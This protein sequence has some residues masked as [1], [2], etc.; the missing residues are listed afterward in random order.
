M[1]WFRLRPLAKGEH[2]EQRLSKFFLCP[3]NLFVVP[4]KIRFKHK[5]KT[6]VLPPMTVLALRSLKPRYGL[7][8]ACFV[9]W[10]K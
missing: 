9:L 5:I 1:D 4:V 10:S 7:D 8:L 3:T 6:K 2:S